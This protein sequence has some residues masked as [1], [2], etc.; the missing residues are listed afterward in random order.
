MKA[1]L[2]NIL[3]TAFITTSIFSAITYTAC[4]KDHCNNVACLNGGACDGGNCVCPTGYEGNRCQT[5]SRDKFVGNYNGADSCSVTGDNQYP[6]RMLAV[7]ANPVEM[8]MMNFLGNPNDS[9]L[10]TMQSVD[11]FTFTGNNNST[12]YHGV[13]II[14][15]DSLRMTYHVQHD[16]INYDCHYQGLR[17]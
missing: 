14:S 2:R 4:T 8:T 3:V 13:G 7:A 11:S 15:N 5:Y 17:Y 12:T 9:A 10:C 16:T 6:I 1:K